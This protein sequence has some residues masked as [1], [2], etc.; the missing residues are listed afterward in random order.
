MS[1]SQAA[2]KGIFQ[3]KI[4]D[5]QMPNFWDEEESNQ[6]LNL[7]NQKWHFGAFA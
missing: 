5:Y 2:G 3:K 7:F 6:A 1:D 4:Q